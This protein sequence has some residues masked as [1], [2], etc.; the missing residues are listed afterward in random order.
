MA[1]FLVV[2]CAVLVIPAL[3]KTPG[4]GDQFEFPISWQRSKDPAVRDAT[5]PPIEL[6][7]DGT[8]RLSG[9]SSAHIE[10]SADA[11]L[12]VADASVAVAGDARWEV[13]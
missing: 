13:D 11:R 3:T 5:N 1:I 6:Y 7:E 4:P 8:A 9:I 2:I 10:E 12:C